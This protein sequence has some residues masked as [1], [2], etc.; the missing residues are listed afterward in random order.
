MKNTGF[1]ANRLNPK[2][3]NPREI[4]FATKWDA[5]NDPA[6]HSTIIGHLIPQATERDVQVAATIAQ[7]LG[8]NVGISF[9]REVAEKCPEVRK[10]LSL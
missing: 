9:I 2:C 7:W 1:S 10:S 4:A 3:D 5:M 8:S 6:M